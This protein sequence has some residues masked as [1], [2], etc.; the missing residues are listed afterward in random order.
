[1]AN[2]VYYGYPRQTAFSTEPALA[3]FRHE[4]SSELSKLTKTRSRGL[5]SV[6]SVATPSVSQT[7][8]LFFYGSPGK[9]VDCPDHLDAG[10]TSEFFDGGGRHQIRHV[11]TGSHS[12]H[13]SHVREFGE[14]RFVIA[15]RWQ[16]QPSHPKY[17][18]F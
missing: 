11:G 17:C 6:S 10:G 1:M 16:N 9:S 5:S 14:W 12:P 3:A 15:N 13:H 18:A 7:L 2:G 4:A 8:D